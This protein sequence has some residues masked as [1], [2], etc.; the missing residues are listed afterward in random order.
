MLLLDLSHT[1]HTRARTGV[2]RVALELRRALTAPAATA[3]GSVTTITHDPHAREWRPL[4]PWEASSLD[5][6][7][8][9]ARKRGTT[10]PLR[11]KLMG[12]WHSRGRSAHLVRDLPT[13][14]RAVLFPEIFT[15]RTATALP[16]LFATIEAPKIAV[17]HDAIPLR[18]PEFSPPSTVGRFPRYLDQLRL[19]D[20]VAA[21]SEDS[22]Q[23]LLDYWAWAGFEDHPPVVAI[24]LGTDH[25]RR[26][27]PPSNASAAPTSPPR[28]LCVGSLE[29]RKNHLTLLRAAQQLWDDGESFELELIGGLQR[30]T[31]AAAQQLLQQ[32]QADG[33]PLHYR[34]WVNDDTLQA[35]FARC[36][37][38]VYPSLLEGFGLPVWESLLHGKPCVCSDRGA[39]AEA[40]REGGCLTTD[41]TDPSALAVAL[42]RLIE[43]PTELAELTTAARRRSARPWTTYA[44]DLLAWADGLP[45]R[46]LQT[47]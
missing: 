43:S 5:A 23:S 16:V 22:R 12:A 10:W 44:D 2:Q 37:F 15:E 29:G 25:L 27:Q 41:T 28:V 21:V 9:A 32:L 47:L 11:A 45:R 19:F 17:F 33:R 1:S 30:E 20:G 7:P 36:A 8:V 26:G 18:L 24:P 39:I 13:T 40:A 34:G 46:S 31:G 35:A 42:R 3:T 38:T 6:P 4:Q 14:A